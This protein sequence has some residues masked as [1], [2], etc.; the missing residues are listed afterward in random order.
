MS[1]SVKQIQ[2][3]LVTVFRNDKR[4]GWKISNEAGKWVLYRVQNKEIEKHPFDFAPLIH[5]S[6]ALAEKLEELID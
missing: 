5:H 2:Q 6:D 4:T 3:G 1:Y